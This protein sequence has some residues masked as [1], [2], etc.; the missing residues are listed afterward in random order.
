[1]MTKEA[2]SG[3]GK[4]LIAYQYS[5]PHRDNSWNNPTDKGQTEHKRAYPD[6]QKR[7]NHICCH[8][9]SPHS[10]HKGDNRCSG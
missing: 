6:R 5:I 10:L 7:Y 4:P 2:S 1:M 3:Y 9:M 8:N